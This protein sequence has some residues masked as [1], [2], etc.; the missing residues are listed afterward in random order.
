MAAGHPWCG[1]RGVETLP[2][3]ASLQVEAIAEIARTCTPVIELLA[4]R[5]RRGRAGLWAQIA[6]SIGGAAYSLH[7]AEMRLSNSLCPLG[8]WGILSPCVTW[9]T[10]LHVAQ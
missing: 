3:R 10:S 9:T 4:T 8:H 7:D 6:D 2:D 5:S 1:R